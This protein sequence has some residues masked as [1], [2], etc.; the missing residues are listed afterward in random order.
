MFV[1]RETG[2]TDTERFADLKQERRPHAAVL[3]R[4]L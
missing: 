2:S 3:G 4:S 1:V